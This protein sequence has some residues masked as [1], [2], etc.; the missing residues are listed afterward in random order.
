MTAP[1]RTSV[2]KSSKASWTEHHLQEKDLTIDKAITTCRAKRSSERRWHRTSTKSNYDDDDDQKIIAEGNGALQP[3]RGRRQWRTF[4]SAPVSIRNV[5]GCLFNRWLVTPARNDVESPSRSWSG[6]LVVVR[7]GNVRVLNIGDTWHSE[8]DI[9]FSC[10]K[11][12]YHTIDRSN[13]APL[14][15]V[16]FFLSVPSDDPLLFV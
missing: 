1:R 12:L 6:L 3:A 13:V 14:G 11:G 5:V 15:L 10:V 8:L 4:T 7:Y 9:S 16:P 2:T